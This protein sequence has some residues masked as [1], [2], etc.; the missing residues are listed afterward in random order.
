M[1][2]GRALTSS[3]F[4]LD[5][6]TTSGVT[7]GSAVDPH[8]LPTYTLYAGQSA[9]AGQGAVT[10]LDSSGVSVSSASQCVRRCH[11]DWSCGC[12]VYTSGICFKR[13]GCDPTAFAVSSGS[14]VYVR[15]A[16]AEVP[17]TISVA[18]SG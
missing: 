13:R 10:D 9:R 17:S 6:S 11:A 16:A 18:S 1:L 5:A 15:P 14:D 12:A 7:I 2:D 8:P 3:D 4:T